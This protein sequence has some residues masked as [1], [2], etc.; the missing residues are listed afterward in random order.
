MIVDVHTHIGWYPDHWSEEAAQEALASKLVKMKQS[1]GEVHSANL[2]LHSYDS[3]TRG[4]LGG[5][6]TGGQGGGVRDT[7]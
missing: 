3:R 5:F 2:D 1:G 4:S 6:G 7:G